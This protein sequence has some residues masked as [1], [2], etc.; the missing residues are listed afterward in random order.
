MECT[1]AVR[2]MQG[3]LEKQKTE[4]SAFPAPACPD[5][6]VGGGSD[7]RAW[8]LLHYAASMCVFI[9]QITHYY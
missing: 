1:V 8:A 5:V 7:A 9:K 3:S 6:F 4:A 2:G